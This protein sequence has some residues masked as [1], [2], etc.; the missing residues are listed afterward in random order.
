VCAYINKEPRGYLLLLDRDYTVN[1]TTGIKLEGRDVSL[2]VRGNGVKRT[3][4]SNTTDGMLFDVNNGAGLTLE[5][6][7]ILQGKQ[8]ATRPLIS[9]INQSKLIMMNGSKITGHKTTSANG[10]VYVLNQGSSFTMNGGEISDNE[11]TFADQTAAGAVFMGLNSEF[12]M[13][14][15]KISGNKASNA[16]TSGARKAGGVYC[17]TGSRIT[18]NGGEIS[19]NTGGAAGG[20]YL[21]SGTFL[22]NDG[23][24][25]G[26]TG[27]DAGAIRTYGISNSYFTMNGGEI[28]GNNGGGTGGIY[29]QSPITMNGGTITGNTGASYGG[30]N[31]TTDSS[32]TFSGGS[33]TGNIGPR[34]DVCMGIGVTTKP[35]ILAGNGLISTLTV[36]NINSSTFI[37][38]ASGWTGEVE[39]L[40]LHYA[41]VSFPTVATQWAGKKVIQAASG[42][43]LTTAD[44]DKFKQVN[45]MNSNNLTRA[46][47]EEGRV[48][49]RTGA[50]IGN[51]Q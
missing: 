39:T 48:I 45:F 27:T 31:M 24:I 38:I 46:I 11:T 20:I 3:I 14:G 35:V 13:N 34:G 7:I 36:A 32:I 15:G 6:D 5:D 2:T 9:I 50:N 25:S 43:T 26:N 41:D 10:T 22:M 21:L 28:S 44:I 19:G 47:S 16:T 30:I 40:N 1:G 17:D 51:L 49:V 12:I 37:Q 4:T 29:S 23:K 18:L 33:I 42:H 8:T